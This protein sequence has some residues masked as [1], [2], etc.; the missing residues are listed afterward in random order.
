[1]NHSRNRANECAMLPF[2][3]FYFEYFDPAN[4]RKPLIGIS[5]NELQSNEKCVKVAV[6]SSH[7][8]YHDFTVQ[9]SRKRIKEYYNIIS[10]LQLIIYIRYITII[11][12]AAVANRNNNNNPWSWTGTY[13]W[14]HTAVLVYVAYYVLYFVHIYLLYKFTS[15]PRGNNNITV[16]YNVQM[17][18]RRRRDG[19]NNIF[20]ELILTV[21]G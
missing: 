17:V 19:E 9:M 16:Y 3:F 7:K 10:W 13:E 1:M 15:F 6:C 20:T 12:T 5:T 21:A 14:P 4:C 18:Q 2:I 11:H 8:K